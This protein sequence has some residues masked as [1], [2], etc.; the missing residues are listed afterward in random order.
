MGEIIAVNYSRDAGWAGGLM[1]EICS[2]EISTAIVTFN[3]DRRPEIGV[4]RALLPDDTFRKVVDDLRRS[5]YEQLPSPTEA[6]PE[7]KFVIVGVRRQDEALPVLRP[8]ELRMLPPAVKLLGQE[9]EKVV[10]EIRRQPS[11]VIEASASWT[12][13]SF[14]PGEP[15]SVRLTLRNAGILP[16][17]LGNPLGP[18]ATSWSGLRLFLRDASGK[19]QSVDLDSSHLRPPP[20]AP[21]DPAPILAPA[22]G[23]TL[24]LKKKVYL[25]PGSYAGRLSY[26][27]VIDQPDDPQFVRGEIWLE[28]GMVSVETKGR[29][30]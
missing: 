28:L 12:K 4:Y 8:F 11:R 2:G 5:G 20:G 23:A 30:R 18:P 15:L 13:P 16:L 22:A 9:I 6:P 7:A 17:A 29:R 24:E 1:A 25:T 3:Y 14:D 10:D 21:S 26:Q 27:N 19:E